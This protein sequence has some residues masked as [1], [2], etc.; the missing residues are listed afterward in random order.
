MSTEASNGAAARLR[1]LARRA[2]TDRGLWPDFSAAA[3]Q[4]AQALAPAS[5]LS[6]PPGSASDAASSVAPVR[7][8]RQL[9]WASIDNE[10]SLDLDQL[11]VAEPLAVGSVK[12]LIAI[13]DVATLV[14]RSTPIDQHAAHNTTS[15]YTAAQVFSMLPQR[16]STDV[17]VL[18]QDQPRA[19]VIVE[20]EVDPTGAI[21]QSDLYRAL[22]TNKAKLAY[23]AVGAWLEGKAPAPPRVTAVAGLAEQLRTQDQVAQA[24]KQ[25]RHTCGALTLQTLETRV[26][27]SA[28]KPSELRVEQ[29]NRA[30]TLIEEF[31]IA[32]NSATARFL[33]SRGYPSVRRVLLPPERWNRI[34]ALAATYNERLPQQPDS[35][36]LNAFL[37]RRRAADP[38][39]FP[40]LSLAVI[41]L[42]G[43]GQYVV[44][45]Q[46]KAAPGHFGLAVSDYTHSTAPNRRF[47][48][49]LTQRLLHAALSAQPAP[50]SL[51]ELQQLAERCTEQEDNAAKVERQ[52]A[53]SAAAML[54]SSRIGQEF[55]GIVTG[56]SAKGT[57]VRITSPPVEGRIVRGFEGL[58]V[59]DRTR[60]R[61][62]ATDI[63][64]GFIDFG[65]VKSPS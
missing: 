63:D 22:V 52:V 29:P 27:F 64:R 6:A 65:R 48:D 40:D 25:Q 37:L 19:S 42:L 43:R 12:I 2:M 47:P 13:A 35:A 33:Q 59:G 17:S 14:A 3:L 55:D 15:V 4:Q 7:D 51:E 9:L 45:A 11:S 41:K 60:V 57:W 5:A 31:M 44:E 58:D 30:K 39:R 23:D 20:F 54:L 8:L 16:L 38:T 1:A 53:K 10:D 50:Y 36:A 46:G 18:I 32:A 28:D 34:A 49:L 21:G 56:A 61:L 24:L 26:I 62:A